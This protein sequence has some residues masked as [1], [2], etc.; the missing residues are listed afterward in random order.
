MK[1]EVG[2]TNVQSRIT[3]QGGVG[4]TERVVVELVGI[5]LEEEIR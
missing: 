4:P 2:D 5:L 1:L 3:T